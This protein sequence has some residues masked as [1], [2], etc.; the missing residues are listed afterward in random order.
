MHL[1]YLSNGQPLLKC[2]DHL[3]MFAKKIL[4]IL[5]GASL[6]TYLLALTSGVFDT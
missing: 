5:G 2:F 1:L 4:H 6:P 3:A